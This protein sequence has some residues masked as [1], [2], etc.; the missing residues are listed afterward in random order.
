[1]ADSL[2]A[3]R[4]RYE[5]D[6]ASLRYRSRTGRF[7][8]QRAVKQGLSTYIRRA[9]KEIQRL[10]GQVAAGTLDVAEWQRLTANLV[11][12]THVVSAALAKGGFGQMT[13]ADYGRVGQEMRRQYRYLRRFAAEVE[14]GKLAPGTIRARAG[15]YMTASR[16]FYEESRRHGA[17][18]SLSFERNILGVGEHCGECKEQT[19]RGWV[20]IGQLV[21]IGRRVCRSNCL[22]RYAFK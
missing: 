9:Q 19:A 13:A 3:L 7:V 16:S 21:P 12:S 5:W 2:T 15:M 8:S 20:A 4:A 1:M 22:C 18:V 10:A 11:K 6:A 17:G 14:T